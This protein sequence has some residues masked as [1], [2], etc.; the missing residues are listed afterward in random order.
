MMT[1]A[2]PPSPLDTARRELAEIRRAAGTA[3]MPRSVAPAVPSAMMTAAANA[4]AP[5]A[6]AAGSAPRAEEDDKPTM[7]ADEIRAAIDAMDDEE[8]EALLNDY[9][10]DDDDE[11]PAAED[12][13]E[14]DDMPAAENGGED[15]DTP[16]ASGAAGSTSASGAIT[17]AE[18][19]A[20]CPDSMDPAIR[21]QAIV[22]GLTAGD[23]RVE[24]LGRLVAMAYGVGET[25]D[26]AGGAK[27]NT[28]P[29][30]AARTAPSLAA[31]ASVPSRP[32]A[33]VPGGGVPGARRWANPEAA[34]QA[35]V[36]EAQKNQRLS[37][38]QAI[39]RVN[40]E[41]PEL[42]KAYRAALGVS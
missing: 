38:P 2:T 9:M 10:G 16:A 24:F 40:Q 6:S 17:P 41:Q 36:A 29:N 25:P 3:M 4:A 28:T 21:N 31:A 8:R 13:G 34:Y 19:M 35:A 12:G 7:T 32:G 23:G 27:P 15:D 30:T 37:Y 11:S 18:A 33:S 5:A 26:A 39:A 42:L 20:L 22:D 14:D 1:T